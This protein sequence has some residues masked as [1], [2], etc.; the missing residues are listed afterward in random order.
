M[1]ITCPKCKEPTNCYIG[2]FNE[3]RYYR[4]LRC[5]LILQ[6][7]HKNDKRV[8]SRFERKKFILY[9]L[10]AKKHGELPKVVAYFITLE[11]IEQRV[12]EL[13]LEGYY[14]FELEQD[15]IDPLKELG[16]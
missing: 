1:A 16:E 12:Q 8:W 6:V 14:R 9:N 4:C 10:T 5:D 7:D 13:E 3:M 15:E 2:S 11:G